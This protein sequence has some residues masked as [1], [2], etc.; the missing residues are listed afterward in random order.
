MYKEIF[1]DTK[2]Q[3]GFFSWTPFTFVLF[4]VLKI[5]LT[6]K[7]VLFCESLFMLNYFIEF[8]IYPIYYK[9][10]GLGLNNF[11]YLGW[12]KPWE[13]LEPLPDTSLELMEPQRIQVEEKHI[14]L[15]IRD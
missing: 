4:I 8:D 2:K 3:S 7:F 5:I 1:E 14:R 10:Y 15:A 12:L 11:T 13:Q 9:I 6:L